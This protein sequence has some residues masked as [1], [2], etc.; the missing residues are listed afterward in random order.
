MTTIILLTISLVFLT[1]VIY[2]IVKH[3]RHHPDVH[4]IYKEPLFYK[5]GEFLN[6]HQ[7]TLSKTPQKCICEG[8]VQNKVKF[9][10][11]GAK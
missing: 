9:C 11:C 8:E 1:I 2:K 5:D 7:I 3:E 4:K 10:K 6:T